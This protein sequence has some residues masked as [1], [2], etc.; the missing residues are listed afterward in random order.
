M[1]GALANSAAAAGSAVAR[2]GRAVADMLPGSQPNAWDLR[3]EEEAAAAAASP[4]APGARTA[5][6]AVP[7]GV[8]GGERR[9]VVSQVLGALARGGDR[10]GADGLHA[11][12]GQFDALPPAPAAPPPPPPPVTYSLV[13]QPVR[14]TQAALNVAMVLLGQRGAIGQGEGGGAGAGPEAAG[15]EDGGAGPPDAGPAFAV[16]RHELAC[17]VLGVV[18]S[19]PG[20]GAAAELCGEAGSAAAHDRPAAAG[21]AS[22]PGLLAWRPGLAGQVA[23]WLALVG[24]TLRATQ[25][26]ARAR[27]GMGAEGPRA[28]GAGGE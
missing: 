9:G 17:A 27:V 22:G 26:R 11:P 15:P 3:R 21:G 7:T 12:Q 25:V 2:G 24:A 16:L 8:D 20:A 19:Q 4:A 6:V 10:D 14:A 13:D 28:G 23:A 1:T 18:A 5:T